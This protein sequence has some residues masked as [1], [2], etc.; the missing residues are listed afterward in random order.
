MDLSN[1]IITYVDSATINGTK[2]EECI[3]LKHIQ[4]KTMIQNGVF[5]VYE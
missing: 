3:E 1:N 4:Y 5:S 2:D